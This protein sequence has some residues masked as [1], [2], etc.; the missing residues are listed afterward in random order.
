MWLNGTTRNMVLPTVAAAICRQPAARP[1]SCYVWIC[2]DQRSQPL[3]GAGVA[4]NHRRYIAC[5]VV[6]SGCSGG[7]L[8]PTGP[9]GRNRGTFVSVYPTVPA[10]R[11]GWM[12]LGQRRYIVPYIRWYHSTPQVEIATWRAAGCRPYGNVPRFPHFL[13]HKAMID[14]LNI[15]YL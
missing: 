8:P 14:T 1:E 12:A 6:Q 10:P 2:I 3:A 9:E 15:W 7:N 5:T 4:M 11:R 13:K